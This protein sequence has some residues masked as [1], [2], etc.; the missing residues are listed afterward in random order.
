MVLL[1]NR[2]EIHDSAEMKED[3]E[4]DLNSSFPEYF[5]APQLDFFQVHSEHRFHLATSL[6]ESQVDRHVMGELSYLPGKTG[7]GYF[8][9][10]PTDVEIRQLTGLMLKPELR[11][12]EGSSLPRFL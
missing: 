9:S 3:S 7:F 11:H 4:G 5:L 12:S 2:V 1:H 6:W 8:G 10:Y